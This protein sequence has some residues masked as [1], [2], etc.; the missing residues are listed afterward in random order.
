MKLTKLQKEVF[1]RAVMTDVP[2]I[3]YVEKAIA[4]TKDLMRKSLPKEIVEILDNKNIS[5]FIKHEGF[6]FSIYGKFDNSAYYICRIHYPHSEDFSFNDEQS[7]FLFRIYEQNKAQTEELLSMEGKL[8]ALIAGCSTLAKA[9]LTLPEELHKYLPEETSFTSNLPM[10]TNI[11]EDL[12]TLGFP[13]AT[14]V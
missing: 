6:S 2:R 1:V 7:E 11:I 12:K 4:Y 3:D 8:E 5:Y 10:V 9:K 14:P 13:K